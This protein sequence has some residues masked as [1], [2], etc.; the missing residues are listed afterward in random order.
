MLARYTF[1]VNSRYANFQYFE[2]INNF[3]LDYPNK[4]YSH[5]LCGDLN[6]PDVIMLYHVMPDNGNDDDNGE[7]C[8]IHD[9][10]SKI[11]VAETRYITKM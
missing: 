3:L 6:S 7:L 2:E 11:G 9:I 5:L 4:D 1:P 10:L 8:E